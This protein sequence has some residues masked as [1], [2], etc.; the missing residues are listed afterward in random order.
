M[1]RK[2]GKRILL[3]LLA[4]LIIAVAIGYREWTRTRAKV[5]DVKGISISAI[6]L[7]KA[8]GADEQKAN[9]K[10]LNKV[11]EVN[12]TVN[13]IDKNQ[14]GG[15]VVLLTSNDPDIPVQCTMR[16]KNVAVEKGKVVT[17]KG[18]CSG[19]SITGILLTDCI[20]K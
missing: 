20:V 11:I 10:Y 13:E 2:T 14:D 15:I 8:Y 9:S 19:S 12:G 5:E 1:S 4:G 16:E 3:V 7:G 17:V 18:F 6:E